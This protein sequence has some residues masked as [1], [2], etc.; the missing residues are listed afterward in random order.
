MAGVAAPK[1]SH[2]LCKDGHV[3][4]CGG[5]HGKD[6]SEDRTAGPDR[7]IISSVRTVSWYPEIKGS[8]FDL[9]AILACHP[10]LSTEWLNWVAIECEL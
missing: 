2:F 1:Y 10:A 5:F 4:T 3:N 9:E 6:Q 8:H 7:V